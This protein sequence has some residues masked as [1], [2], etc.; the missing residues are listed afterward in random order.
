MVLDL[1]AKSPNQAKATSTPKAK[2]KKKC[3]KE[4]GIIEEA[5]K[6]K[7]ATEKGTTLDK[8]G[9]DWSQ[10]RTISIIFDMLTLIVPHD[11]EVWVPWQGKQWK[12]LPGYG[13]SQWDDC[14]SLYEEHWRGQKPPKKIQKKPSQAGTGSHSQVPM[15]DKYGI[16]WTKWRVI[17]IVWDM[18]QAFVPKD[19][20]VWVPWRGRQWR[21]LGGFKRS[22]WDD[23]GPLVDAKDD[24]K[25]ITEPPENEQSSDG[26]SPMS[27][28]I[29]T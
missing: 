7:T 12:N 18:T 19:A 11:A 5:A 1:K 23:Q 13:K 9:I 14:G 2:V 3:T 6:T 8:W 21:S 27:M 25:K 4:E 24:D 22:Q 26:K 20:E 16:D 17:S 10:W 15:F 29:V 28:Q